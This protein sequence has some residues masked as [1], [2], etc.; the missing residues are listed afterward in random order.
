MIKISNEFIQEVQYICEF[1][2][3]K[4]RKLNWMIVPKESKYNCFGD[5]IFGKDSIPELQIFD[6]FIIDNNIIGDN[7][8]IEEKDNLIAAIDEPLTFGDFDNIFIDIREDMEQTILKERCP[9]EIDD[10]TDPDEYMTKEEQYKIWI[11]AWCQADK[12][13]AE[14]IIQKIKTNYNLDDE[15]PIRVYAGNTLLIST[16]QVPKMKEP[17]EEKIWAE[18][19]DAVLNAQFSN[20]SSFHAIDIYDAFNKEKFNKMK[21]NNIYW[22]EFSHYI[23][24]IIK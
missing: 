18:K 17:A 20:I 15:T 3:N 19:E 1:N 12:K 8:R 11:E 24:R 5:E 21:E 9:V 4:Y 16:V 6:L 14:R 22:M 13:I 2:K 23:E 10:E 7:H